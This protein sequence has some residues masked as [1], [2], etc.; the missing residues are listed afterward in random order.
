MKKGKFKISVVNDLTE[1]QSWREVSGLISK[2]LG[3]HKGE[4]GYQVT[5]L[6][7]GLLAIK[8]PLK[9]LRTAKEI[10]SEYEKKFP[11]ALAEKNVDKIKPVIPKMLEIFNYYFNRE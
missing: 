2:Y 6:P 11:F 5:H 7:T 3:I 9:Y 8:Y 4:G 1:E 10:V